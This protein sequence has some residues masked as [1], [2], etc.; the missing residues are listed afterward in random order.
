MTMEERLKAVKLKKLEPRKSKS[1]NLAD[2]K[3]LKVIESLSEAIKMR[4]QQLIKNDIEDDEDDE[5]DDDWD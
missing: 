2:V 1:V 3:H 4:R 5:K